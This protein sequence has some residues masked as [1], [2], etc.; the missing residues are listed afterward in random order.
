MN[1][2]T[3]HLHIGADSIVDLG[4]CDRYRLLKLQEGCYIKLDIKM[5]TKIPETDDKY[6]AVFI[7]VFEDEQVN[8]DHYLANR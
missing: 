2:Y 5:N 3:D 4:F 1:I 6:R 8:N 7:S